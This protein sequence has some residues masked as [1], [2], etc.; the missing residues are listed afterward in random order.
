MRLIFLGPP[1]AGKGTQAQFIE[2]RFHIPQIS[3]GDMLRASA[4]EQSELGIEIQSI[5]SSGHL[6][7]DPLIIK[8]VQAR[9]TE[10][11]CQNGYILDGFP[12]T[13]SQAQALQ[14]ASVKIDM[15]LAVD[16]ADEILVKRL[17]GRRI[18]PASGRVYHIE[19]HPP[20]AENTDD[21]TGEPLIQREDDQKAT[22]L[23]RLQ[24]YR[25]QTQPVVDYY[26]QLATSSYVAEK[27]R[28]VKVDGNQSS[29]VI[30]EKIINLINNL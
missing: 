11:D 27:P 16:V 24:I 7:P 26:Y 2:E 13:V 6:V 5:M 15:V 23:K 19:N 18:H 25:K 14:E 28:F 20:V 12:R 29:L 10:P 9:I 17:S 4:Q 8:L 1:G 3:T 30:F 22:V 21:I